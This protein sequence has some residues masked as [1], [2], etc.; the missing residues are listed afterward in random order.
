MQHGLFDHQDGVVDDHPG[1]DDEPQHGQHIKRLTDIEVQKRKPGDAACPGNRH[2]GQNDQRQDEVPQ[3]HDHQQ[4]D[5]AKSD[6]HIRLHRLPGGIKRAGGAAQRDA[7]TGLARTLA[8]LRD[9]LCLDDVNGLFQRQLFCRPQPQ[10]NGLAA[11][12]PADLLRRA[13]D[14]DP[15][16]LAKFQHRTGPGDDGDVAKLRRGQFACILSGKDKVDKF[17]GNRNLD[18]IGPV[19]EDIDGSCDIANRYPGPRQRCQVGRNPD[20][21]CPVIEIGQRADLVSLC[22]REQFGKTFIH[23]EGERQHGLAAWSADIDPDRA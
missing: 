17:A 21:R 12:N 10:R 14:L 20:L 4:E 11:T 16:Q 6:H 15:G 8:N 22:A 13:D 3:Q 7:D 1:E 5:D 2:R 9:K 18:H 23:T 19:I